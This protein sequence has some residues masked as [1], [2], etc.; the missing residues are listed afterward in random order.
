MLTIVMLEEVHDLTTV[1]QHRLLYGAPHEIGGAVILALY[2][3][4]VELWVITHTETTPLDVL[5]LKA[6]IP[7]AAEYVTRT[8]VADFAIN[9]RDFAVVDFYTLGEAA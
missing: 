4:T 2:P 6:H 1:E 9:D 8:E 5:A 3:E 7:A